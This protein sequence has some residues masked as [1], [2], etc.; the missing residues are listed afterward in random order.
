MRRCNPCDRCDRSRS[1]SIL[2][3]TPPA[4]F[5]FTVLVP[6]NLITLPGHIL[7]PV[8]TF[9]PGEPGYPPMVV[10]DLAI[11]MVFGSDVL[12]QQVYSK[13]SGWFVAKSI[14]GTIDL[15]A[16]KGQE[17]D[18][19]SI[20]EVWSCG[21]TFLLSDLHPTLQP[22]WE[23]TINPGVF[24]SSLNAGLPSSSLPS[25]EANQRDAFVS[26][27]LVAYRLA[28]YNTQS[29]QFELAFRMAS[30]VPQTVYT[31]DPTDTRLVGLDR[32][33]YSFLTPPV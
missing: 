23:F 22:S 28:R 18:P 19:Y 29:K 14:L 7:S 8:R 21:D 25:H 2:P 31:G 11:G 17:P 13:G 33:R 9:V 5:A 15:T 24:V 26:S 20:V 30:E 16:N 32:A 1:L 27:H 6:G 10:A 3:P 12:D 4:R